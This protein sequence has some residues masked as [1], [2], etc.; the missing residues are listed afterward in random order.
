VGS[1]PVAYE[2]RLRIEVE[3]YRNVANV[4]ELPDIFH[5]WTERFLSPKMDAVFGHRQNM[6]GN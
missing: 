1:Q 3:R 6:S 2:D 4:H 5:L